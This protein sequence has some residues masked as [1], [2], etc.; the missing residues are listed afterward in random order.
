M[1]VFLSHRPIPMNIWCIGYFTVQAVALAPIWCLTAF[2]KQPLW[3]TQHN[4][5][6]KVYQELPEEE[7][8]EALLCRSLA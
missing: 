5:S 7:E 4:Q 1:R 8:E 2:G 3:K 6:S